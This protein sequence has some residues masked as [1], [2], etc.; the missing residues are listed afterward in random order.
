[1]TRRLGPAA[2]LLATV[3]ACSG[4]DGYGGG[5]GQGG[6]AGGAA[7]LELPTAPPGSG[8]APRRRTPAGRRTCAAV[9]EMTR[10][11]SAL[12]D[13]LARP[14][15]AAGA[16][17]GPRPARVH[18]TVAARAGPSTAA[19]ARSSAL[20]GGGAVTGGVT[21]VG[22]V[23]SAAPGVL[24]VASGAGYVR[25]LRDG[26]AAPVAEGAR[27]RVAAAPIGGALFATSVAVLRRPAPVR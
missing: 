27:V 4:G 12:R 5:G 23:V 17:G 15:L 16:L 22:T 7:V 25:L 13:E 11:V 14:G 3:A 1:M 6:G 9:E 26:A 24:W 10:E 21:I 8:A 20:P 2:V 19:R 18:R